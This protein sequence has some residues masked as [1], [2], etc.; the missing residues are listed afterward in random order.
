MQELRCEYE[1]IICCWVQSEVSGELSS[2]MYKTP[3]I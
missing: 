2:Q 1:Q 3:A